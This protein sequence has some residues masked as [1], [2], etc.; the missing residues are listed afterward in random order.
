MDDSIS[1]AEPSRKYIYF[2]MGAT[3]LTGAANTIGNFN[4][5]KPVETIII[6]CI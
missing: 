2:L 4:E 6:E 5:E 3:I 1:G